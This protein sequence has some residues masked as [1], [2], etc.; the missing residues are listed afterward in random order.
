MK[1]ARKYSDRK[2]Y[3]TFRLQKQ[4]GSGT[5]GRDL[6]E[7]QLGFSISCTPITYPHGPKTLFCQ[8]TS[9]NNIASLYKVSFK[10]DGIPKPL[11]D[12]EINDGKT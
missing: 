3:D 9:Y 12:L 7:L 10:H 6:V 8:T 1:V 11:E 2:N 4:Y 5:R